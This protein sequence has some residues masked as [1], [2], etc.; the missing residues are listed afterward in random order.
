M[1]QLIK[2]LLLVLVPALACEQ[3]HLVRRGA[4]RPL[5]GWS[6]GVRL[7]LLGWE[8]AGARST[9]SEGVS[10]LHLAKDRGALLEVVDSVPC[11]AL[12]LHLAGAAASG[13]RVAA[14]VQHVRASTRGV[15]KDVRLY[16]GCFS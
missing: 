2:T 9:A 4:R 1:E 8:I 12:P 15:L 16:E 11:D 3:R 7:G 10:S 5:R 13:T 14:H 6:G